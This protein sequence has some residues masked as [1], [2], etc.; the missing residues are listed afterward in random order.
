MD[1][2]D[3]KIVGR[4]PCHCHILKHEDIGVIGSIQIL[5]M[6]ARKGWFLKH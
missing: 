5:P 2:G 4:F 1:F 3:P 6:G